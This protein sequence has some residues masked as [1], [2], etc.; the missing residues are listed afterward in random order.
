MNEQE[1]FKKAIET[2]GER[3]QSAVAMEECGE[4]IRAV[5]KMHRDPSVNH[6]NELIGEIADVLIMI[7]QLKIIYDLS[8]ADIERMRALK[9]TRL[10]KRLGMENKI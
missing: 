2:Y 5:N 4:L 1:I 3:E 6:H 8:P 10:V 7:E 9:I